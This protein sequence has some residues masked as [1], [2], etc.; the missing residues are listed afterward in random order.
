MPPENPFPIPVDD[1][2]HVTLHV[3]EHAKELKVDKERLIIGGY[4]NLLIQLA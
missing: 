3:I 4:W 1:C 2:Y